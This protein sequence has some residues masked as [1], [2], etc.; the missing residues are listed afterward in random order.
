MQEPFRT[1]SDGSSQG[2]HFPFIFPVPGRP[3]EQ[4]TGLLAVLTYR[5]L[6]RPLVP[7]PAAV[8]RALQPGPAAV[9]ELLHGDVARLRRHTGPQVDGQV[10]SNPG[11]PNLCLSLRGSGVK[12]GTAQCGPNGENGTYTRPDGSQVVGTRAP[13]GNNFTSNSYQMNIGNSTYNSF[14]ASLERRAA[15]LRF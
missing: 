5:R 1:R 10:E 9:A 12:A 2:T 6:T 3:G 11:D 7:E 8:R 15:N 14:Q 4:D 13:F